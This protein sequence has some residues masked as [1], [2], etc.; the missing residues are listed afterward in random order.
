MTI[1]SVDAPVGGYASALKIQMP[2][3]PRETIL[4][5]IPSVVA[6][7]IAFNVNRSSFVAPLMLSPK[8]LTVGS[9]AA[10]IHIVSPAPNSTVVLLDLT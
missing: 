6:D 8:K 1:W 2:F 9:I 7:G 10:L 5:A 3:E 4:L